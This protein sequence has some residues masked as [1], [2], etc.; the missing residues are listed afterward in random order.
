[1]HAAGLTVVDGKIGVASTQP[2]DG[3][4]TPRSTDK[5]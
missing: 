1:M 2:A 3:T 5:A 4:T